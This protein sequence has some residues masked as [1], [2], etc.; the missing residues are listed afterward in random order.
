MVDEQMIYEE[1]IG[2][3]ADTADNYL[4]TLELPMTDAMKLDSLKTGMQEL[5]ESLREIYV[6]MTGENPWAWHK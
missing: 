1:Q 4:A 6:E 2:R 3:L 5:L